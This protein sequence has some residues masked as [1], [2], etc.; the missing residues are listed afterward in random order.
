[1]PRLLKSRGPYALACAKRSDQSTLRAHSDR[2]AV[3]APPSDTAPNRVHSL[4]QARATPLRRAARR[5]RVHH[6]APRRI[7]RETSE[8]KVL[9]RASLPSRATGPAPRDKKYAAGLLG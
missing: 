4:R 9:R 5:R 3:S 6:L 1:M 2:S 8:G 7:D